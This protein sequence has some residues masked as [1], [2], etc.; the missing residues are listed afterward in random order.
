VKGTPDAR[1][2]FPAIG[3]WVGCASA[4]LF[5][6]TPAT[7][8]LI[9]TFVMTLI[10]L[11]KR[12][13]YFLQLF[14]LSLFLGG[15][16]SGIHEE[17]LHRDLFL[18]LKDSSIGVSGVV[19]TDPQLS[20]SKIRGDFRTPQSATFYLRTKEVNRQAI[21]VPILVSTASD[22]ANLI[23]GTKI[24][25]YGKVSDYRLN[26][27]S[28]FIFAKSELRIMSKPNRISRLT[29][30]M[31]GALRD[32][33]QGLP[34]AAMG[35]IPG[36][37]IGDRTFQSVE[38]TTNMRATGLT[39]LTAVSG[40][41]LAIVAALVLALCR[42]VGVKGRTLWLIVALALAFFILL[43]RPSPSVLRAAVMTTVALI[44]RASGNRS[45]ALPSLGVAIGLLLIFN[46][47]LATDPG[48][49]LS[50]SATA[51]LLLLAP[52]IE[53]YLMGY[54]PERLELLAQTLAIPISATVFSLPIVV[55]ISGQLS[56]VS[57][58]A[59]LIVAPVIAPITIV[60]FFMSIISIPLPRVS[61]FLG[62]LISPF[63]KWIAGVA[64][65]CADLSF[66]TLRWSKGWMGVFSLV[67]L[68][69]ALRM[70]Y[71]ILRRFTYLKLPIILFLVLF[72]FFS[73]T[74]FGWPPKDWILAT[75]D[76]GQGDGV[77]ISLGSNSA[78]VIDV[79]P[80]PNL[81]DNCLHEL[82][83]KNVELLILTHFHADHVEG[84]PG[85][86]KGRKVQQV[87]LTTEPTPADEFLRVQQWLENTPSAQIYRGARF[88]S[89]FV[90]LEVIW[91]DQKPILESPANNASIS[92]VGSI[93]GH[94]FFSAGDLESAGQEM[95]LNRITGGVE[96][97]KVTHHGSK[98]QNQKLMETL[99][100]KLC[101]IS[102]G[103]DNP[104][105]HPAPVTLDLLTHN[106]GAVARTDRSG[107][108][109]VVD[110][111]LRVVSTRKSIW[112]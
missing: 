17:A 42:R 39:H 112:R 45:A 46:P 3:I 56:L 30:K 51:G 9:A 7:I 99:S 105:G 15:V 111:P 80:D 74:R 32:C 79:G 102:V 49:A 33:L 12:K 97:L 108:L 44:A 23:P 85:L 106:C 22:V 4:Q 92:I 103:A 54:F 96:I 104:Y 24:I 70:I 86:L 82:K 94:S 83:V 69:L 81:I 61:H 98:L 53:S 90:S 59:N 109:I 31:R 63:A 14:C 66:S 71:L 77:V 29:F 88:K 48:F 36:I 91:P 110:N 93:H 64:N 84:L 16:I 35:L 5:Y 107:T 87:W 6:G 19:T 41:N 38:L 43:V 76:V 52:K 68:A 27:A 100:P 67:L 55:A 72:M 11:V 60:G 10:F 58:F 26:N 1:L 95:V 20:K 21:R 28:A 2:L 37:V 57:V 73:T 62:V 40:A 65:F 50:V 8:L 75:C 78:V 18:S 34:A 101:L 47:F 13:S 25:F 89:E